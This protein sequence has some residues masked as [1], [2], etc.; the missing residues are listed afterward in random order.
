VS[1]SIELYLFTTDPVFASRAVDSGVTGIVIDWERDGKRARQLSADTEINED[2]VDD[3]R[4]I[5]TATS[6]PIICRINP[7]GA[8]TASEV[9][10]AVDGGADEIL[11]PMV[12]RADEVEHVL[13]CTRGRAAIGILVET[14]DAVAEASTL[15]RLPLARVYVGLNDLAIELGSSSIF[16]PVR[17][18]TVERLRGSFQAPF[19]ALALTLPEL[20]YPI[21]CRLLIG[22]L[23]RLRCDFTIL[24]RSFRRDIA[25]KR[26]EHELPRLLAAVG[27]ASSRSP[28]AIERDRL[29]LESDITELERTSVLS[30]ATV[31]A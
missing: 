3:L 29:E 26:L 13:D 10:A 21:P 2:T 17:D 5:R 31:D 11:V 9:E 7:V 24:R 27:E 19:G 20:G 16:T 23:S 4:R 15:A 6:R 12:R 1:A 30:L 22:E 14:V 8:A 25:G 18:G 28:H